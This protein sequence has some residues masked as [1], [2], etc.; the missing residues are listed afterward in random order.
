[1]TGQD[2]SRATMYPLIVAV[3]L[4]PVL[5]TSP[6]QAADADNG[7]RLARRWCAT[8]HV[9]ASNQS[10]PTSEAP[11]FGSI[12]RGAR[13]EAAAVAAFLMQ[14]HPKMPDMSLTHKE[15]GDLAAYIASLK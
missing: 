6:T 5:V 11:P 15:A 1:M 4:L 10:T 13:F 8:C 9:V 7:E 14:S 12:A 3:S 2:S